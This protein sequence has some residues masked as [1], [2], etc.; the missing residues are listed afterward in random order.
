MG[1]RSKEPDIIKELREEEKIGKLNNYIKKR[2]RQ[3]IDNTESKII[4]T[5]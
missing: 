3:K 4:V 5:L 1:Y 2:H